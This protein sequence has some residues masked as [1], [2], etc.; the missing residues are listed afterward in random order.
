MSR[1][2]TPEALAKSFIAYLKEEN[3]YE[4]LPLI[5]Q[6]LSEEVLRNQ[7]ITVISATALTSAQEKEITT[8]LTSKWG[9][10][11]VIFSVDT[12]LLS[13]MIIHFQDNIIDLSGRQNLQDLKQNLATSDE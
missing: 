4:M 11:K 2:A 7:D 5:T 12:S 13:G 9:D 3:L 1:V 8:E 10:H 6:E